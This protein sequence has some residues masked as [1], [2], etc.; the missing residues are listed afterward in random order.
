MNTPAEAIIELGESAR[1]AS[2][3][4]ELLTDALHQSR[5]NMERRMRDEVYARYLALRS[6][7]MYP[8]D[9]A[10]QAS[11]EAAWMKRR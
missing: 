10:V 2:Q 5:I 7:G 11:R 3:A 9:A 8:M 1:V 6:C 4:I